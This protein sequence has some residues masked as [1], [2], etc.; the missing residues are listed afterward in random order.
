[1]KQRTYTIII[2]LLLGLSGASGFLLSLYVH[3]DHP[4]TIKISHSPTSFVKQIK[5]DKDAGRKIFNEFCASCHSSE[6]VIGVNAPRINDKKRWEAYG[7][8]GMSALLKLTIQGRGAMPARGGCFEC[9]DE[10]LKEAVVYMLKAS[11]LP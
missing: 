11:D 6:P 2:V 5:G 8:L 7:K 9:S 3:H 4:Q 10:Q 1:M